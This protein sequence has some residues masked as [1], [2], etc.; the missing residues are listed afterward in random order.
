MSQ[1]P[2]ETLDIIDSEG[3]IRSGGAEGAFDVERRLK[4][5]DRE[6]IAGEM[7]ASWRWAR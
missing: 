7:I 1:F 2:E 5:M 6:G 4:E 3:A